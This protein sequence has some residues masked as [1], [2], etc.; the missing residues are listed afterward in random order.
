MDQQLDIN[1][2]LKSLKE[3]IGDQAQQIA[4]LRAT[5]AAKERSVE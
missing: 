4:I 3:Q 2:V 1:E 5:I